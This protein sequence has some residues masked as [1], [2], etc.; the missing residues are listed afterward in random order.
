[1]TN[2]VSDGWGALPCAPTLIYDGNCGFC[3]RWVARLDR[4]DRRRRIRKIASADRASLPDLPFI[5]DESLARAMHLVTPDGDVY[6]GA[7]A[8]RE[9]LRWLPGGAVLRPLFYIPG[10]QWLADVTYRYIAEHRDS[11]SRWM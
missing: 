7:A 11:L 2:S 5:P 3:R 6:A 4:W 8:A 9:M 10:A 1:M